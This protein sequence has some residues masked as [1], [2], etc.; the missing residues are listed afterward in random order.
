M[1]KLKLKVDSLKV[2]SFEI[3]KKNSVKGTIRG[4]ETNEGTCEFTCVW[5]VPCTRDCFDPETEI[6]CN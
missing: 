2:D 3:S 6:P 4:Q 5:P 1:K